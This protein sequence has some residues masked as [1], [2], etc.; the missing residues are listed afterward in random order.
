MALDW[1]YMSAPHILV[2][3]DEHGILESLLRIF[4]REGYTVSTTDAG[5]RSAGDP[6]FEG[7]QTGGECRVYFNNITPVD[8]TEFLDMAANR[9]KKI[10]DRAGGVVGAA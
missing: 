1:G 9:L 2:V 10:I 6:G 8:S 3:D 5:G 7:A 4:E